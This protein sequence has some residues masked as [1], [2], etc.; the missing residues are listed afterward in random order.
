MTI[1]N[2][3]CGPGFG[4]L[5]RHRY[6]S[7]RHANFGTVDIFNR[8]FRFTNALWNCWLVVQVKLTYLIEII[9]Y[10]YARIQLESQRKFQAGLTGSVS[11][12]GK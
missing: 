10:T 5:C 9:R 12:A 1:I 11:T 2:G 7:V 3:E 6:A 4:Y 8:L